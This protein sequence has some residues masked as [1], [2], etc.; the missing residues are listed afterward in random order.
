MSS[1]KIKNKKSKEWQRV[2]GGEW[3]EHES[4]ER[5]EREETGEVYDSTGGGGVQ[6]S[7]AVR[8]I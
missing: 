5:G 8:V 6:S 3:E 4:R 1:K 7:S 2:K